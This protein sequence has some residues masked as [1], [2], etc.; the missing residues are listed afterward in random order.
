MHKINKNHIIEN[1]TQVSKALPCIYFLIKDSDIVYIGQNICGGLSRIGWHIRDKDFDSYFISYCKAEDL[2]DL[3][4]EMIVKFAPILNKGL[5]PN[6]RYIRL[7]KFAKDNGLRPKHRLLGAIKDIGMG[8]Y[9]GEYVD[10]Y[11]AYKRMK[12]LLI[13]FDTQRDIYSSS[14]CSGIC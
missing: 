10:S 14:R 9:Y 1:K 13:S 6:K 11:D 7:G 4:S 12:E 5:P 3:E 2:N 8:L